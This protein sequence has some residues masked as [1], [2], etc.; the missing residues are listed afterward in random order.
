MD[1]GQIYFMFS[2]ARSGTGALNTILS[3]HKDI[4]CLWEIF[5]GNPDIYKCESYDSNHIQQETNYF[6]WLNNQKNINSLSYI[7]NGYENFCNY[8]EY[9]NKKF[10]NKK[11]IFD[12]KYSSLHHFNGVWFH[13]MGIP[14]ILQFIKKHNFPCI[15]LIRRNK[16]DVYTSYML[17]YKNSI[18]HTKDNLQL[19]NININIDEFKNFLFDTTMEDIFLENIFNQMNLVAKFEYN[20]MFI[21]GKLSEPVAKKLEHVLNVSGLSAFKASFKKQV[22]SLEN[23]IE[24]FNEVYTFNKKFCGEYITTENIS[25]YPINNN[26]SILITYLTANF[27]KFTNNKIDV[28]I[29]QVNGLNQYVNKIDG[30][31]QQINDIKYYINRFEKK[32]LRYPKWIINLIACFVPKRKNRHNLRKKYSR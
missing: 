26:L 24:N 16:L 11:I 22:N 9:I 19:K 4:V 27:E 20:D 25:N 18:W 1:N 7:Q 8:L 15:N 6:N 32:L 23:A 14:V 31:I 13:F 28:V 29:Q 2:R 17:A 12:V 30:I 5:H 21:D 3:Q 10:P